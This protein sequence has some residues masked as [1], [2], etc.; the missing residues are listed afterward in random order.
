MNSA[1]QLL[2]RDLAGAKEGLSRQLTSISN[3]ANNNRMLS[4]SK[5]T[6]EINQ[7][8]VQTVRFCFI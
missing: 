5:I 1:A 2:Q 4:L 8:L 3:D 7:L 6:N